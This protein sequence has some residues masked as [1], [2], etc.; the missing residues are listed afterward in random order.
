MIASIPSKDSKF[1]RLAGK[2]NEI[3]MINQ[4][5][6]YKSLRIVLKAFGRELVEAAVVVVQQ[7]FLSFDIIL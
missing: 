2:L 7:L 1:S 3:D 5:S 4:I 6:T